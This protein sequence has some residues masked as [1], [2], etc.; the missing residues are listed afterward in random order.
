MSDFGLK[1]I[2]KNIKGAYQE[3]PS[4]HKDARGG[5]FQPRN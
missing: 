2:G 5:G 4:Y 3:S 1:V